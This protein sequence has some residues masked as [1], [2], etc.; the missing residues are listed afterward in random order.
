MLTAVLLLAATPDLD[1]STFEGAGFSVKDGVASS[2]AAAEHPALWHKTF[3]LPEGAAV[4]EFRAG[5]VRPAGVKPGALIDVVLEAAASE[6]LPRE[7]RTGGKWVAA[8][9]LLAGEHDYRFVVAG[10]AGRRVRLAL[11]DLD[12]RAGCH[13]VV[14]GLEVLTRDGL[15]ERAFAADMRAVSERHGLPR[16]HRYASK[17]FVAY[18]NAGS[19]F[20]KQRL[21][22]CEQI[23]RAFFRHFR[24]RGFD[25]TEPSERLMVVVP[26]TQEGFDAVLGARLGSA[27]T[28]VYQPATNRLVVY[29]Y[30]TNAAFEDAKR[31]ADEMVRSARTDLERHGRSAALGRA[32][33][34]RRED[35]NLSTVMHEAAHQMAF[36][37]GLLNR[38]GDAPA[39]LVEGMAVYCEAVSGGSWQGIG[40]HNTGRAADLARADGRF[41][42]VR[43]L[44]SGDGW[45]RKAT[46]V[47]EVALGYAQSWALFKLLIEERPKQLKG[48]MATIQA[49]RTPDHR[50]TDFAE[51][52]GDLKRLE[53][54]YAEHLAALA[55]RR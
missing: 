52:F 24:R 26:R 41:L 16:F 21:E 33:R 31:S 35:V 40:E 53:A 19:V 6:Y 4:I 28:G 51:A 18:G 2:G 22:D 11:A 36:N 15:N 39:W 34:E 32:L 9:A 23:H 3:R 44:A 8:P 42:T 46:T 20:V 14:S 7:V 27:V 1:L 48:Y 38:H 49:R 29:D 45:L 30:A 43:H 37:G 55:R 17:H 50:L 10:H 12:D 25:V 47:R 13:V 54:R 5:C